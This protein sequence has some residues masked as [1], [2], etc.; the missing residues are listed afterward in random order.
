MVTTTRATGS[1]ASR[2]STGSTSGRLVIGARGQR[3]SELQQLLQGQ[4]L[5]GARIDGRFGPV[6]N[7]AVREFQRAHG[8][9]VDGWAGPKT[10]AALRAAGT[11][12]PGVSSFAS[13]GAGLS[14]TGTGPADLALTQA[15]AG[16]QAALEYGRSVI[17]AKYASVNP[18]RFGDIAWPGGTRQ[19][20]NGS[21]SSYTYPAGTQVFDCS[22]FVVACYRRAGVDLAARGLATSGAIRAN[23][24]GFL[25]NLR[26]DELKPGDL[27]TY[28]GDHNGVGHVVIYLGNNQCLE[29]SG[30]KG[31]HI[32]TVKWERA[33][34]FRRVPGMDA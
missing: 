1:S 32:G 27:I 17:G 34:S 2:T 9:K 4:G 25:Q 21:G 11:G 18:Y 16:V 30:S 33:N 10:M 28:A 14:L 7:A 23:A 15:G 13:P 12:T 29:C 8:L 22:G 5:Y 19:S 3:V 26:Q 6:T 24:G 31:V 20:V